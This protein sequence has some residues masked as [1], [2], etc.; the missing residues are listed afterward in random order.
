MYTGI[1]VNGATF[2]HLTASRVLAPVFDR[3]LEPTVGALPA[4]LTPTPSTTGSRGERVALVR[5]LLQRLLHEIIQ[6]III[7]L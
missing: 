2:A 3:Q 6:L 5:F 7:S 4:S 1:P